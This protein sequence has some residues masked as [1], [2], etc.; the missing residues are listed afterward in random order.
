MPLSQKQ[1][2]TGDMLHRAAPSLGWRAWNGYATIQ[3][4][5]S[6]KTEKANRG[7][8]KL[9]AGR[10]RNVMKKSAGGGQVGRESEKK[11]L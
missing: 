2:Q 4:R 5:L 1:A 6:M 9:M 3:A 11:C 8:K 10:H 7:D